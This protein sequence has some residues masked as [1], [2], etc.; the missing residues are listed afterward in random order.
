MLFPGT[1]DPFTRGHKDI[2]RRASKLCDSLVIAVMENSAKTPLFTA[3]ERVELVS[4]SIADD[5]L[6][7]V[8]VMKWG[9]LLVDLYSKL[10]CCASVRG[11]RSES[12]FR[13]EAELA[14]ANR[15]LLPGYDAI[16]L[17][18][19]DDLSLISSSIVKEVG[20]YGGDISMMVPAEIINTVND[21]FM[22]GRPQ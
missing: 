15:L 9:G 13:Y 11:I 4:R 7:N 21:K 22:K 6:D 16:L 14:L 10:G 19:R 18:C 20:F 17:P 1:F 12:D 8:S 2:A 5:G 3:D